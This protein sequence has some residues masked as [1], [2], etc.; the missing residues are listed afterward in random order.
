MLKYVNALMQFVQTK[1][2]VYDYVVNVKT[3]QA[4]L[5]KMYGDLNTSFQVTQNFS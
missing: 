2:V 3:C 1:G 5:Y 4:N